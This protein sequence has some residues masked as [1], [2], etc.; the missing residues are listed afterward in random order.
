[1]EE[2]A[3]DL[4]QM[5]RTPLHESH[6]QALR[7]NGEERHFSEREM[8]AN[9]GDPTDHFVFIE[10]GEIE[11]L[12][13][14]TGERYLPFA[15]GPGQY[16]GDI[17]FLSG[18]PISMPFRA[19]KDTRVTCVPRER[20]LSLM[21]AI[22]EM[23]DI[24]ITVFAARRRRQLEDN[25]SSLKLIGADID[26][27]IKQIASFASRNKIPFQSME[28]GTAE[29]KETAHSCDITHGKPAVIYGMNRVIEDPTPEKIAKL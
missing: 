20:M 29:A 23:S 17:G 18:A 16:M 22:P 27:N 1:M 4:R 19:A 13:P 8:V 21:S 9:V 10:E 24:I 28:L 15:L 3:P 14:F 5:A 7:D 25:D 6:I 12:D 11:V 26:R 2:L